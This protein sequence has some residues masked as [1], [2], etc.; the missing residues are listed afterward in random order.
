MNDFLTVEDV[1]SILL[2]YDYVNDYYIVD[3]SLFEDKNE[4]Y[5][6]F[7]RF[8]K[9]TNG[10]KFKINNS[11]WTGGVYVLNEN[12]EYIPLNAMNLTGDDYY[13]YSNGTLTIYST[14]YDLNNCK[15]VLY[16]SSFYEN[17]H[18]QYLQYSITN[19]MPMIDLNE[20]DFEIHSFRYDSD[21]IDY[22]IDFNE[23]N[24]S[25]I[26]DVDGDYF[27]GCLIQTMK[28]ATVYLDANLIVGINNTVTVLKDRLTAD[29]N[30]CI[31]IYDGK[32][33]FIDFTIPNGNKFNIDLT[34]ENTIRTYNIQVKIKNNDRFIDYTY[35]YQ[36]N[37]RYYEVN[38]FN[39]LKTAL[40]NKI[41]IINI[42][43]NIAF[44]QNI[45]ISNDT[46]L[47]FNS[48]RVVLNRSYGFI[49]NENTTFILKN[50]EIVAPYTLITQKNGSKV[51]IDNCFIAGSMA[52]NNKSSVI[53]CD[54]N[55]NDIYEDNTDFTTNISNSTISNCYLPVVIHFGTLNIENSKFKCTSRN[56][57]S[58]NVPCFIY[59]VKGDVTIT[60]S[61]FKIKYPPKSLKLCEKSKDIG[62]NHCNFLIGENA[63]IN[64]ANYNELQRNNSLPFFNKPF[65]N[66]SYVYCE[67]YYPLIES[68]VIASPLPNYEDKCCC[69]AL[70]G[71]DWV[72]KNNV[73][74]TRKEWGTENTVDILDI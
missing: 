40:N 38:D 62:I 8:K 52:N 72:F 22:S 74:I 47:N 24:E 48:N 67:Y 71:I 73:Q 14:N 34:D 51:T 27:Y 41:K 65:N 13:F 30:N 37:S 66:K 56:T 5:Y 45:V 70:S 54:T 33:H 39:D 15:L 49:V 63:T 7:V 18:L 36:L 42:T 12:D 11:L 60:D 68:C 4:G 10:F 19:L 58:K 28:V 9:I 1:N 55:I 32:E 6:D 57:L 43:N 26:V 35:N 59:Q 3:T 25:Y 17:F 31:V 64:N 16:L 46:I 23:E 20:P 21:N 69:H 61:V 50:A 29:L 2:N 44:T 53:Q